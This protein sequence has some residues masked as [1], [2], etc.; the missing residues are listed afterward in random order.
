MLLVLMV[1]L[2]LVVDVNLLNFTLDEVS[3]VVECTE[4]NAATRKLLLM[5]LHRA[6][7]GNVDYT[8]KAHITNWYIRLLSGVKSEPDDDAL[9]ESD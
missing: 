7:T 3:K 9:V 6:T 8:R 5:I 2:M 4:N 1:Q